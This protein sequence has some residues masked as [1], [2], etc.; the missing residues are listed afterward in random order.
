MVYDAGRK[1]TPAPI[2]RTLRR[3]HE[4]ARAIEQEGR[5]FAAYIRSRSRALLGAVSKYDI[6]AGYVARA[7]IVHYDDTSNTDEWQREVYEYAAALARCYHLSSVY[8]VGCG[9]GYKL[10][11]FFSGYNTV[12]L[13]VDATVAQLRKR[14]PER[15]WLSI[16]FSDRSLPPADLVICADVIEHVSNPDELLAFLVHLS[17]KYIV[18]STPDRELVSGKRSRHLFG[19]PRN[20][21]HVREWTFAEFV[22]Y[23]SKTLNVV[24]HRVTNRAQGTQMV[25]ATVSQQDRQMRTSAVRDHTQ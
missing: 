14:Y 12:G 2:R 9:S 17:G 11:K 16:A 25:V 21:Y 5:Y 10:L 13:D 24:E 7:R 1:L 15:K 4:Q 20:I 22:A 6:A 23:V 3:A 18:L 8:D 19:P